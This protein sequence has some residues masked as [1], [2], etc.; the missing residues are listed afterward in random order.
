MNP[1]LKAKFK[2]YPLPVKQQLLALRDLILLIA[3]ED[4]LGCVEESLKWGE[5]SYTTKTG[6]TVR[7]DYKESTPEYCG[8][9]FHCQSKLVTTFKVLYPHDF[10]YQGNRAIF[11]PLDAAFDHSIL[12]DC[13]AKALNYHKIKHLPLLGG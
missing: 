7:I 13:L 12:K 9:Y 5:P 11:L 6:S 3:Q 8:V 1:L 4:N 10:I 2:T